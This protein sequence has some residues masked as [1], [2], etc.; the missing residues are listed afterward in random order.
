MFEIHKEIHKLNNNKASQHSDIPIKI[1]KRNSDI[2][3]GFLEVSINDSKILPCFHH[4]LK[5]WAL[6][7]SIWMGKNTWK[8]T[9]DLYHKYFTSFFKVLWKKHVQANIRVFFNI[10]SKNQFRFRK[11]HSTQQCLLAMLEKWKRSVDSGKAFAA[12]LTGLSKAFDCLD[13]ELLI[14][15]INA[16]GF[17]LPVLGLI[18]DYLS[19]R[20]QRTRVHTV[21][22]CSEWLAIMFGVQ[23][24]SILGPLLFNIFLVDLFLIHRDIDIENFAD[25]NTPYLSAESPWRD[26]Q[27][28]CSDSLKKAFWKVML[29]NGIFL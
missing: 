16:Y 23:Q 19:H 21:N 13:Y 18:Q 28:L 5:Q 29:I 1:I 26:L 27:C 9:I 20:K 14:A 6:R 15:K 24:G 3:S 2:F 7:L 8:V 12:V 25:D 11:C 17:S 10:F 22:S 4:A